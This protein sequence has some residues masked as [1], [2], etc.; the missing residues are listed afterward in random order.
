MTIKRGDF[1]AGR[2][3]QSGVILF[4]ALILLVILSMIGV[5]LARM[6]TVE[7]RMARNETSRQMAEQAAEAALRNAEDSL[8]SLDPNVF[9]NDAGGYYYVDQTTG[10]ATPSQLPGL[11]AAGLSAGNSYTYTGP[12]MTNMAEEVAQPPKIV[13]EELPSVTPSGDQMGGTGGTN[14]GGAPNL[15]RVTVQAVNADGTPS[16]MLQSIFGT[17]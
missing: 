9:A 13:I 16:V 14:G 10:S 15:F 3:K 8:L 17:F 5:T 4:V 1:T 2:S 7:E 6:Q 11:L 12:V